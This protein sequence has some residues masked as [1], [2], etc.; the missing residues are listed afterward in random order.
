MDRKIV[1]KRETRGVNEVSPVVYAVA[2]SR[3]EKRVE[4]KQMALQEEREWWDRAERL[5]GKVIESGGL[6]ILT[7]AVA[8]YLALIPT[9]IEVVQRDLRS[10]QTVYGPS[11][12]RNKSAC[13]SQC[14]NEFDRGGKSF[15]WLL[16]CLAD[17]GDPVPPVVVGVRQTWWL[18]LRVFVNMHMLVPDFRMDMPGWKNPWTGEVI[19]Q[20]TDFD[21]RRTLAFYIEWIGTDLQLV[22][23]EAEAALKRIAA[24]ADARIR[25]QFPLFGAM[26]GANADLFV[27]I[28]T[29][30]MAALGEMLKGVGE[31]VPG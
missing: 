26:A 19:V 20:P 4:R 22:P 11:T 31:I 16:Q 8:G 13:E 7:G 6:T 1:P 10:F 18:K 21:L 2:H 27:K 3:A 23:E 28:F 14:Y 5:A 9:S 12:G 24:R 29:G 25:W 17:C 15:D 30:G